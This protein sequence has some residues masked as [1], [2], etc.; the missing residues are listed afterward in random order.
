MDLQPTKINKIKSRPLILLKKKLAKLKW[1]PRTL[2]G[3]FA[4]Q[5][6]LCIQTIR[7]IRLSKAKHRTGYMPTI[8][9]NQSNVT[10]VNFM[11]RFAR[12]RSPH[13]SVNNRSPFG[14]LVMIEII[15][16]VAQCLVGY[17]FVIFAE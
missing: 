13:A 12:Y 4:S 17:T 9:R 6:T 16:E 15:V 7:P 14:C 11:A 1:K 3:K 2:I 5:P 10:M 8:I